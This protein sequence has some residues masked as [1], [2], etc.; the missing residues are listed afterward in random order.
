M[1]DRWLS[2]C[3][4][5]I[6]FFSYFAGCHYLCRRCCHGRLSCNIFEEQSASQ[7]CSVHTKCHFLSTYRGGNEAKRGLLLTLG[8]MWDN[9]VLCIESDGYG[10]YSCWQNSHSFESIHQ[11]TNSTKLHKRFEKLRCTASMTPRMASWCAQSHSPAYWSQMLMLSFTLSSLKTPKWP[12]F[13]AQVA[14]PCPHIWTITNLTLMLDFRTMWSTERDA[15]RRT[16]CHCWLSRGRTHCPRISR[17][18]IRHERIE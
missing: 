3:T 16:H 2:N 8:C 9:S 4:P 12:W 15:A 18:S 1:I 17:Q 6:S 13:V 14:Y 11:S 10:E 5:P 7:D